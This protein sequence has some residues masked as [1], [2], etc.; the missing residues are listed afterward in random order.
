MRTTLNDLLSDGQPVVADGGMGTM[1][2]AKGL[3][4]GSAPE[5]WNVERPDDVRSIHRGYIEAG[6]QI[7]LTN[8]FGGNAIRLGMHGL[9]DRAHELNCAGAQLAR[10]EADAAA[11][12]VVVGGSMGPTGQM[13]EPL[14]DLTFDDAA[15]V[16]EAQASALVEGGVDVL[17][18]ETMA[19]LEEVRAAV[20]GAR[21]AAPELPLVATM[22]FDTRGRTMMGVTPERAVE[23]LSAYNVIALGA[24]CGNGPDELEAVI[25]KMHAADPAVS[26]IA[27]ANAGLPHMEDGQ[28][29]YDA[30]PDVMNAYAARVRTLGARIVGACCGSTPDHIRAIAEALRT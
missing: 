8:T 11:Q 9:A 20:E 18:I 5:V 17:W 21:R 13:L 24:N 26:L 19:D 7:V 28:A 10:Q 27:K 16:F 23:T 2:F 15:A 1:L 14:G 22:T 30:S 6:A 3:E 4:R 25:G 12:P 29:V